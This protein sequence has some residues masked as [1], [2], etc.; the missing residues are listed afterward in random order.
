MKKIIALFLVL[1]LCLSSCKSN[2]NPGTAATS[3]TTEGV[4]VT[5]LSETTVISGDTSYDNS[6]TLV[7]SMVETAEQTSETTD[8]NESE[9]IPE[10]Y[11]M[12]DPAFLEYVEKKDR[13]HKD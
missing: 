4:A 12:D 2:N 7:S 11:S 5:T 3:N 1:T 8:Y 9:E 6:D 10:F 13:I